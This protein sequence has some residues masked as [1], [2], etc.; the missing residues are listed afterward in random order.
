MCLP[1]PPPEKR[2]ER[3]GWG[4]GTANQCCLAQNMLITW[5][6]K[7]IFILRKAPARA[8]DLQGTDPKS[9]SLSSRREARWSEVSIVTVFIGKWKRSG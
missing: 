5:E 4:G 1:L 9:I 7:L 3:G 8:W 6:E 2:K